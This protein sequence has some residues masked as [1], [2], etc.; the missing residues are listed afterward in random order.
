MHTLPFGAVFTESLV[1]M[2]RDFAKRCVIKEPDSIPSV[3][4]ITVQKFPEAPVDC[5]GLVAFSRTC[6]QS[7]DI[8]AVDGVLFHI[9][10]PDQARASGHALTWR[11]GTGIVEIDT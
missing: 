6:M 1:K 3:T 10:E 11:D 5:W 4:W 2:L 8:F 9:T 7:T